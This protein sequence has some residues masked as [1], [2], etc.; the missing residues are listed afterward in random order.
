MTN[1]NEKLEREATAAGLVLV[2]AGRGKGYRTYRWQSCGHSAEYVTGTVRKGNVRCQV[3]QG[4]KLINEAANA[5]LVLVGPGRAVHYRSYRWVDCGHNAEYQTVNVRK[6]GVECKACIEHRLID[7]ATQ[8]GLVLIG[9]GRNAQYR[10]YRWQ[11]CGHEAEY[12]T[13]SVRKGWVRCQTCLG[14]KLIDEATTAGLVMIGPGKNRNYRSYRWV[15]CG[16][17]AEYDTGRVREGCVCCQACDATAWSKPS[18]IYLI[19]FAADDGTNWLKLG[20]AKN[21]DGR[22]SKYGLF[23]KVRLIE[24]LST[25][26]FDTGKAATAVEKSLHTK[27][28]K[29]RMHPGQMKDFMKN[30]HTECY[31]VTM[32][33]EILEALSA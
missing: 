26:A 4:Q 27:F 17:E 14:Q 7:E 25:I 29:N 10:S 16:H 30:G 13:D 22:I 9:A 3:C 20:V 19:Q 28:R 11:S 24:R 5:G 32:R 23:D 18:N 31:P 6:G 15:D 12:V 2:G 33:D 1:I 21:I 8:A